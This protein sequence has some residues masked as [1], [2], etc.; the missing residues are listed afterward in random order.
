VI[1]GAGATI[2]FFIAPFFGILIALYALISHKRREMP[3]GPYLSL[4]TAVVMLFYCPI[5][6]YLTPGLEGLSIFVAGLMGHG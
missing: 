4:A 3:L 2:A 1:G 5:A 6:A